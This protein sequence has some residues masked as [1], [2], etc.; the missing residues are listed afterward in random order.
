[1]SDA[2]AAMQ[3]EPTT[4]TDLPRRARLW[5]VF[6]NAWMWRV[7]ANGCVL[8]LLLGAG[9]IAGAKTP[10]IAHLAEVSSN[11]WAQAVAVEG[12]LER[13]LAP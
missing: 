13:V 4:P 12:S 11:A 3:D 5:R 6:A 2:K 1:M 7:F 9:W 10:E 8:A